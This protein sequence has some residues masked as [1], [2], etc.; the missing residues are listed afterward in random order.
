MFV[1]FVSSLRQYRMN[2]LSERLVVFIHFSQCANSL[3]SVNASRQ[4]NIFFAFF[5]YL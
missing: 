2:C 5:Q 1:I 3:C 4:I